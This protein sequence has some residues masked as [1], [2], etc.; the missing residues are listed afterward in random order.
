MQSLEYNETVNGAGKSGIHS[1]IR[2]L[3]IREWMVNRNRM[4]WF[5]AIWLIGLW[6][7]PIASDVIAILVFGAVY[8]LVL[9]VWIGGSD[10]LDGSE[11][12]ALALPPTRDERYWTRF[13]FGA[14]P[15]LA[16][17]SAG[18]AAIALDLPQRLWGTIVESGFTEPYRPPLTAWWYLFAIAGSMGLFCLA[19]ALAS[20][21]RTPKGVMQIGWVKMGLFVAV[22]LSLSVYRQ[23]KVPESA[24]LG[25]LSVFTLVTAP[26]LALAGLH[27]YRRKEAGWET[28][29]G[30]GAV[31]GNRGGYWAAAIV[32]G[33]V[34]AAMA[35]LFVF[36]RF[37]VGGFGR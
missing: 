6:I 8:A 26:L 27:A 9:G 36:G 1:T 28:N 19:F 17:T 20:L 25:G 21:A 2:G 12:F 29:G 4:E 5:L 34:V 3:L 32:A 23:M 35:A 30:G 16:M 10:V 14:M 33:I 31:G 11:E 13:L 7:L 37:R 22:L 15:L 18:A 24:A